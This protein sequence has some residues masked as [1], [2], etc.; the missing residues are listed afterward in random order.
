VRKTNSLVR[1]AMVLSCFSSFDSAE[2][3]A[4]VD[5]VV[6]EAREEGRT[7]D[8]QT[9]TDDA[10]GGGIH[11]VSDAGRGTRNQGALDSLEGEAM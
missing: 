5:A 10:C 8:R 6:H 3:N 7:F 4:D 11:S 1:G 9:R 2:G